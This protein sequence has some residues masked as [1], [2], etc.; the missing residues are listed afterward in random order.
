MLKT[1]PIKKADAK[2]GKPT[3]RKRIPARKA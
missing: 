1:E 3:T 2:I